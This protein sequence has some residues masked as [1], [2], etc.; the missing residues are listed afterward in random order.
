MFC[1]CF[2]KRP[3][4]KKKLRLGIYGGGK[5]LEVVVGE[6]MWSKDIA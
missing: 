1:F 2:W 6:E 4:E 3:K 5:D